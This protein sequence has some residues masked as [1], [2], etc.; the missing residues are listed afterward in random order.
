[1]LLLILAALP[2]FCVPELLLALYPFLINLRL[3]MSGISLCISS[4]SVYKSIFQKT[5]VE[6]Y[7][8]FVSNSIVNYK[9]TSVST[10]LFGDRNI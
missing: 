1:M 6:M 8:V 5:L 2:G 7:E 9:F 4:Q 3:I 10:G